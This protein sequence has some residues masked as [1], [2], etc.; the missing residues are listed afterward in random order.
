[1][2]YPR[3]RSRTFDEF[4]RFADRKITERAS[5]R[6][7]ATIQR[8]RLSFRLNSSPAISKR[9]ENDC[10]RTRGIRSIE[11][12]VFEC[13]PRVSARNE[14]SR[15]E[16]LDFSTSF[17]TFLSWRAIVASILAPVRREKRSGASSEFSFPRRKSGSIGRDRNGH[18]VSRISRRFS[19]DVERRGFRVA[20]C[21]L[22]V[23]RYW[24]R[25]TLPVQFGSVGF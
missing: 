7:R 14:S 23:A 22:R 3:E 8:P 17:T 10:G 12:E 24:A 9:Y 5:F 4:R 2:I 19:S 16:T 1:M 11:I 21:A 20:C 18:R 13:E 25:C 6:A 15:S